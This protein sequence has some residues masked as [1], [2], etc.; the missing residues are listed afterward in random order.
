[1]SRRGYADES[2]DVPRRRQRHRELSRL[3]CHGV[4]HRLQPH[5]LAA[6][7]RRAAGVRYA[8]ALAFLD[9]F[10]DACRAR[11]SNLFV[12][13]STHKAFSGNRIR[14]GAR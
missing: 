2:G 8:D 6:P 12:T 11:G 5:W 13:V 14:N 4:Q 7:I 10:A 1:M 9:A 3:P